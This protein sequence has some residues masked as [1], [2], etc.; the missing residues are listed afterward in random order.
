[1]SPAAIRLLTAG[2]ADVFLG[3][4]RISPYA[5]TIAGGAILV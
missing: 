4:L 2:V 1:M 3:F 5:L